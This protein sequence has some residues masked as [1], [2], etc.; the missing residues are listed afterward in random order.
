MSGTARSSE[1]L[2]ARRR[3][4]PVDPD[5]QRHDRTLRAPRYPRAVPAIDHRMRQQEQQVADPRRTVAEIG[6]H[7][8]LDQAGDLR[9][10]TL[11]RG[12]RSKQRI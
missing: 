8:L 1:G 3:L 6:R 11:Q 10:D 5:L 7:H 2:E 12:D 4:V 9:P